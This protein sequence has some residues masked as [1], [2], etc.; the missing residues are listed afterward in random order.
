MKTENNQVEEIRER[1]KKV[2]N[3]NK[4]YKIF[5]IVLAFGLLSLFI[6]GQTIK[7]DVISVK[8]I[9][10]LDEEGNTVGTWFS[11]GIGNDQVVLLVSGNKGLQDRGISL[12]STYESQKVDIKTPSGTRIRLGN[13]YGEIEINDSTRIETGFDGILIET[14]DSC[15]IS[16]GGGLMESIELKYSFDYSALETPQLRIKDINGLAATIERYNPWS[17]KWDYVKFTE[18]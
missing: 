13:E 14:N 2:E 1:L 4:H 11:E 15:K 9:N 8:R 18:K 16:L 5:L 12:V 3:Q 7:Q 6:M 17:E 10:L